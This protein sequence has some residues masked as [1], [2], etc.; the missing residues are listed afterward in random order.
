MNPDQPLPL[1]RGQLVLFSHCQR[2][3][4][5]QIVG[6]TQDLYTQAWLYL[7]RY[8]GQCA[9]GLPKF[10]TVHVEPDDIQSTYTDSTPV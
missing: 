10:W 8:N 9:G 2:L 7:V 4:P 3:V 6:Y 5:G 1:A